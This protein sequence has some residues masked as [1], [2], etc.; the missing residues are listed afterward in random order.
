MSH[1]GPALHGFCYYNGS[2]IRWNFGEEEPKGF[3]IVLYDMDSRYYYIHK[4]I[5]HSFKYTTISIDDII[6]C[7]P[8]DIIKYINDLR[9]QEGIDYIRLKCISNQ[10][11]QN[12]L[13]LLKEYYRLDKTVKFKLEKEKSMDIKSMDEQSKS[14]YDQYSYF[15]NRSMSPY[16]ILARYIN[17]SQSDIIV[18]ADQIIDALKEV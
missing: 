17:E 7:D 8:K 10:D 2:P 14:L 16:D 3:Q 12:T 4:E 9:E 15:F 18:T 5:I 6:Q 1:T 13:E 11:T